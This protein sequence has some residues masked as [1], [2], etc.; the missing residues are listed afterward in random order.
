MSFT[1]KKCWK[2]NDYKSETTFF[3]SNVGFSIGGKIID[4]CKSQ[5]AKI[6]QCFQKLSSWCHCNESAFGW[7]RKIV[8]K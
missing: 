3:F 5:V 8:Q 1:I 7:L 4:Q 2:I 6:Q